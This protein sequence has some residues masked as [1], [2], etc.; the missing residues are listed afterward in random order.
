MIFQRS[1]ILY[2]D[3]RVD[4][5]RKKISLRLKDTPQNRLKALE[6]I[7]H[8][9][10]VCQAKSIEGLPI[11]RVMEA[12][13]ERKK[14]LRPS[15]QRSLFMRLR[16]VCNMLTNNDLKFNIAQ[17][18]KEHM[19]NFYNALINKHYTKS[20]LKTLTLVLKS[21]L[22]FALESEYLPKNPFYSQNITNTAISEEVQPFSLQ[23][24]Q[25]ILEACSDVRL[26]TYLTIAFF[27]G[28]RT[29][30][31]LAL[32]WSDVNL[33]ENT[34][35]I[36]RTLSQDGQFLPP[37]T[38]N[39]IRSV[40]LLPPV[41]AAL[42]H[43]AKVHPN[44]GEFIFIDPD[45]ARG[46]ER[47]LWRAWKRLLARLHIPYRRLYTT[48]HTFASLMLKEKE[49]PLWV[50]KTLGHKDLNVTFAH[51]AKFI[52]Q[53]DIARAQFLNSSALA[54][55]RQLTPE[56]TPVHIPQKPKKPKLKKKVRYDR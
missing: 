38:R 32:K 25:Q 8:V 23:E 30:E 52:P 31:V 46:A 13:L 21:F 36:A 19:Q 55:V 14:G 49:E 35:H 39:G 28:A 4:G 22:E 54:W 10:K 47:P 44:L 1:G 26:K 7:P 50:S 2:A 37:K 40:D 29:G 43:Y 24:I 15:T 5:K 42:I 51:Y 6:L 9:L 18:D 12:Y 11:E 53:K 3:L 56:R 48:R 33:Q 41:R 34:L 20:H 17:L 27:T 45:K 16:V